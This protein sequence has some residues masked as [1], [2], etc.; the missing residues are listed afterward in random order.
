MSLLSLSSDPQVQVVPSPAESLT[1][2]IEV[3]TS[4]NSYG[5]LVIEPLAQG[6]GGTLGSALRRVLLSSLSGAAVTAVQI[7]GVQHEY[8]TLPFVREDV[9]DILLNVKGIRLR[10]LT[11]RSGI[12]R[13]D[14]S[15]RTGAI[16]AGDI[17]RS[18]E[19]QIVNPSHVLLHVDTPEARVAIEFHVETGTGYKPAVNQEGQ[20][21]GLLPVDA[22]FTPIRRANFEVRATRVG[23]VIDF[24]RLILEVWTDTT[25]SPEDAVRQGAQILLDQLGPFAALGQPLVAVETGGKTSAAVPVGLALMPIEDLKLSSRTQNSLRRG[26]IATVG[27]VLEKTSDELLALRNFGDR[28]L[29]ELFEK[30]REMGIRIPAAGDDRQWRKDPLAAL[31]EPKSAAVASALDAASDAPEEALPAEPT[32]Y[33][34]GGG[35]SDESEAAIDPGTF[36]R[37]TF[38]P[39][40]DEDD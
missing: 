39:D 6:F 19:F 23:Q 15:G 7:E 24:D 32:V 10:S 22:I 37:R 2:H 1:P 4:T 30:L 31:L 26:N 36:A 21:I 16:T 8:S 11:G 33:S 3:A 13:L 20:V 14:V 25:I 12:L 35:D 38:S 9:I 40:E 27:Q 29:D 34:A 17:E 18:G 5:R 28:S